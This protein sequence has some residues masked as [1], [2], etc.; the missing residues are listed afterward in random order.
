VRERERERER[1][2]GSRGEKSKRETGRERERERERK[3]ED[4]FPFFASLS[5]LFEE[6][7]QKNSFLGSSAS[8]PSG[9]SSAA[10]E[11]S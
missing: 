1:A 9:S 11:T 5:D 4:L 2:A 8:S 10:G 3:R 7:N 6:K